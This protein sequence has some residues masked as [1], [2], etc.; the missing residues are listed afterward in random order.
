MR[1]TASPSSQPNAREDGSLME[2]KSEADMHR[3]F[4]KNLFFQVICILA[5]LLSITLSG[6]DQNSST[7][8]KVAAQNSLHRTTIT[9]LIWAPDWPEQMLQIADEF[10]KVNPDISINVQFMIGDSVEQNI[11]PRVASGNLPD[12]IS[13]NPNSYARELADLGV[14]A[15]VG[16]TAAWHNMLDNL[17]GDW[18]ST[19]KK[20]FGISGGIATTLMYYNK[21]IFAKAGITRLPTDFNEF[22]IVCQQ[23]KRAGFT[24][25]VWNGGFPNMLGNG[26]FS[27]GF[28]NNVAALEPAWK[29]KMAD[30]TL[31]LNTPQVANIFLRIRQM[32]DKG[33]VQNDYMNTTYD[34]GINLFTEGKVAMAFQGNWASGRL[35]HGRNFETG[36]FIPPWNEPEKTVIPV[37][38]SETGFAVCETPNKAAAFRFLEFISGVGF[39]ELQK[40]RHNISPFKQESVKGLSE[41]QIDA[42]T[43]M[44]RSYPVTIGLYYSFLPANT[45]DSLHPLIEDVLLR[46]ITPQEAAKILDASIKHEAKMHYK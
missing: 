40:K 7:S 33:Y 27:F 3:I 1:I 37:V 41:P 10:N 35:M 38:G 2:A 42:Y 22:L 9:A 6:C 32:V 34:E 31:N 28:G 30:G 5:S 23:L 26:P 18:I 29:E 46:K 13:I 14:L 15:D 16:Q 8:N 4:L 36:V 21:D 39:T 20:P 17:D 25:I 43:S 11:K 12:I 19:Q 24:P 44:V 45:I